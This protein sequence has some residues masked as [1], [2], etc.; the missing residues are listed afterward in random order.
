MTNIVMANLAKSRFYRC[1]PLY[2]YNYG[3]VLRITGINLPTAYEVDFAND[4]N[5]TS[6]TQ[7][8]GADGVTIPSQLF[9]PGQAIYCWLREHP[10][11]DSGITT[12]IAVIPISPRATITDE[13]PTPEEQSAIDQAIAALNDAV[14]KAEDAV[15]HYPQITGGVWYVWD[16]DSGEYVSTGIPAQGAQGNPGTDGQDGTDGF[17]PTATVTKTGDTATITITDKTGTTTAQISDGTNGAAGDDGFSPTATVTQ[18]Q[19]GATI[20]ITDK[21]GTTTANISNGQ[22]G[23]PGQPGTDGTDGVSPTVT[24]TDITGGHRVTITD[25]EH[26]TGQTF[27]V[28]DGDTPTVPVQDVQVNGVSVLS[29]GVANVPLASNSDYGVAKV[30]S[31]YGLSI[32]SNGNLCL[33]PATEAIIKAG[34][35]WYKPLGV[36]DL[37][38]SIFYGLAKLAGADMASVSGET[39][40]MYPE[41]QKVAIQKMLGIYEAPWELIREDTV[42]HATSELLDIT[43]DENGQ[44]FEL[45]D[46]RLL[47]QVPTQETDFIISNYA[48]VAAYYGA[49]DKIAFVGIGNSTYTIAANSGNYAMLLEIGLENGMS[50]MDGMQLQKET[51]RT[52]IQTGL[53]FNLTSTNREFLIGNNAF[54]KIRIP[55]YS[56]TLKYRLYGKR[57]WQ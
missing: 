8:G 15:E 57:K 24:V 44:A 37:K 30:T 25:A 32:L 2:Q 50:K 21:S 16:V 22:D 28:M 10:T 43:V 31:S 45:T 19:T 3:M 5:G 52:N 47:I 11:Q 49:T 26:P 1:P 13:E 51:G 29:D 33:T 56:G 17:S 18:T 42:T 41:A 35:D 55:Y 6:I 40:G 20:S 36:R 4:V 34:T 46:I 23:S 27:D 39:V 14:D 53:Y 7:I 9:V 48:T 54:S 12:A 38:S